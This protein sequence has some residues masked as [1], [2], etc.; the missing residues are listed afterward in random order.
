MKKIKLTRELANLQISIDELIAMKNALVEVGHRILPYEF[1]LR[2]HISEIEAIALANKLGEIIEMRQSENTEVEF[3]YREVLGL[4]GSLKEV[5]AGISMPNFIDLIGLD[6]D[7]A[8]ALLEFL[9][10]EV[11]NKMQE[12]TMSDLIEKR[13]KKIV[14]EFGLNSAQLQV[15]RSPRLRHEAYFPIS[16]RLFIFLLFTQA[17]IGTFSGIRIVEIISQENKRILAKSIWQKIQ[18]H[19]L[20]E[21]VAYLEVC[22]DLVRSNE[23]IEEYVLSSYNYDHQNIFRIQVLSG[24]IVSENQGFLKLNF[25]WNANQDKEYLESPDNYIEIEDLVSFEDIDKFTGAICQY[26]VEFY[27]E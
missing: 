22:K 26:L 27:G 25:S 9:L 18:I 15:P 6:R 19:F 21:I 4:Q 16:S 17:N 2:V 5:Y 12:G 23:Q 13:R 3:T 20:S 24:T 1:E 8:L 7:K 11:I 14:T 10:F